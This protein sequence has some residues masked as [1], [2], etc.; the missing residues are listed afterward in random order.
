MIA[1]NST[2]VYKGKPVDVRQVGED[3]NVGYVL[4]G[5]IQRQGDRVRVTAQLIDAESGAHV[6]SE[7]W[8]RPA[9]DL[10]AVQAELADETAAKIGGY[11]VVQQADRG[12]ARRKVARSLTAYELTILATEVKHKFT[13]EQGE[14]AVRLATRA[15]EAD[16]TYA[17]A[18]L[19][20]A[21][22]HEVVAMMTGDFASAQ[23]RMEADARRALALDPNDA[24]AHAALGNALGNAGRLAEARAEYDRALA[25]NPSSADIGVLLAMWS[26]N[27]GKPE[28]GARL[29]EQAVRLNPSFPPFYRTAMREAYF[30]SGRFED[31]V[32]A[33][34]GRENGPTGTG[35]GM[36]L[37]AA[38]GHLGEVEKGRRAAEALLLKEVPTFSAELGFNLG[39][40]FVRERERDLF[41]EG[42]RK[43]GLRVCATDAELA[44]YPNAAR[45]PECVTSRAPP[46]P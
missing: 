13:K 4:E 29:I 12:K 5:S 32:R 22:S 36:L 9:G 40:I 35:D 10:F 14:E 17:R 24:E 8:D 38:Y 23:P 11:G 39:Y 37:A 41:V 19:V 26:G 30:F 16:P 46:G 27:F 15:I 20:R 6:W 31:A 28:R 21:W 45:L 42:L 34:L 44:P 43:A 3:L 2:A 7:R 33:M 25:L 18:W 1:R